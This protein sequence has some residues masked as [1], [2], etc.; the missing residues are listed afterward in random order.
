MTL[1]ST[2]AAAERGKGSDPALLNSLVSEREPL[3]HQLVRER[4][5]R[6]IAYERFKAPTDE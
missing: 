2:P 3:L 1:A 6:G 4:E 5:P